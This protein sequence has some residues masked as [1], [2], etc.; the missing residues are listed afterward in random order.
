M[1]QLNMSKKLYYTL[2]TKEEMT[3]VTYIE[4]HD[5]DSSSAGSAK[6]KQDLRKDIEAS[7]SCVL[8]ILMT[9]H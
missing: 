7:Y 6:E 1:N 3:E 5:S 4:I 9:L 2:T 8:F